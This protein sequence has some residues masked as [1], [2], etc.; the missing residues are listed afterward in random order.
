MSKVEFNH[1]QIS[2]WKFCKN[3]YDESVELGWQ[4]E[5]QILPF[6]IWRKSHFKQSLHDWKWQFDYSH[7]F[8]L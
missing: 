3:S 4:F 2:H 7:I 8:I 5:F 1:L 6:F